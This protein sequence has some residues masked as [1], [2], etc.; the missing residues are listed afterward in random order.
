MMSVITAFYKLLRYFEK[1][2]INEK[3]NLIFVQNAFWQGFFCGRTVFQGEIY[4]IFLTINQ[5]NIIKF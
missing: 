5:I 1:N 4:V 3:Y 2:I